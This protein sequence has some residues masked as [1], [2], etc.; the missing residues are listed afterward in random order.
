MWINTLTGI[1]QT[2][3]GVYITPDA[4][5]KNSTVYACV[6]I[7]AETIASLPLCVYRKRSDGGKDIADGHYLYEKLHDSP[8]PEQTAF[9][10]R[11]MAQGHLAMRG[12]AFSYLEMDGAGRIVNILPL[13]PVRMDVK[14][15]NGSIVYTYRYDTTADPNDLSR[16]WVIPS[17]YLWHIKGLS[18]DGLVG[19]SPITCAREAIGLGLAAEEF[20]AQYFANQ[21]VAGGV[22]EH[23]AQLKQPAYEKLKASL[24]EYASQKR[25]QTII[26][27]EGM[28]WHQVGLANKDSQF[29]ESRAFQV[30]D[31]A[32]FFRMPLIL[33]QHP[34]KAS[35]YASAEQ[36]SLNFVKYT[37]VPWC[38]RWE[39]S[40]N[41]HLL[42]DAD[43]KAGYFIEFNLDALL[44]GD[45]KA[46][47]DAYA[48]GRQ[49]GWLSAND[50]RSRENMNP[51][52]DGD[53]Y[54][55]APQNITGKT[56]AVDGNDTQP[57]QQKSAS[58]PAINIEMQKLIT[59][60]TVA[61]KRNE[62]NELVAAEIIEEVVDGDNP[63][64]L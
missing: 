18:T 20:G 52:E 34:D 59:R 1:S 25:H 57:V 17:E 63:S 62:N 23:P 5:M 45:M 21:A 29:L 56:G 53:D 16:L 7:L 38:E 35:T 9:E 27:E 43:R 54:I 10:F 51:I 32:R 4:A 8:N 2:K 3:S 11:E 42:T 44:R 31:I 50:I 60:K 36:F 41:L 64:D 33:L 55:T 15:I 26:L 47:Y 13:N 61:L 24:Q 19:L 46:R 37:M 28:K 30:E 12:N 6:S 48:V 39:Q 40:A 22:L 58:I 14:R 49:W